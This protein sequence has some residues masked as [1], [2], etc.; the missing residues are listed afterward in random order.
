MPLGLF[1]CF[2]THTQ[3]PCYVA[4]EWVKHY[5][6]LVSSLRYAVIVAAC[7]QSCAG[8]SWPTDLMEVMT[9]HRQFFC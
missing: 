1:V 5:W 4:G 8:L 2:S 6:T 7:W 9:N 3:W